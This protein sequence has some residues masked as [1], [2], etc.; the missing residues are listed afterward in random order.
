MS[1][2]IRG[3]TL[4]FQ[5]DRDIPPAT[6]DNF[7]QGACWQDIIN[8]VNLRLVMVRDELEKVVGDEAT[9]ARGEAATLRFFLNLEEI[10]KEE[11]IQKQGEKENG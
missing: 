2:T 8:S 11:C 5:N 10:I 3:E 1:F 7:F 9:F 6:W 4:E